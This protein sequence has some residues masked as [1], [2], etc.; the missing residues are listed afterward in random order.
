MGRRKYEKMKRTIINFEERIYLFLK[1]LAFERNKS[2]SDLVNEAIYNYFILQELAKQQLQR[3][4]KQQVQVQPNFPMGRGFS[5]GNITHVNQQFQQ[6]PEPETDEKKIIWDNISIKTSLS[7]ALW[8]I[9]EMKKH[10]SDFV[11]QYSTG[12]INWVAIN[13]FDKKLNGLRTVIG[14]CP[15]LV[16]M[17][18]MELHKLVERMVDIINQAKLG[19]KYDEVYCRIIDVDRYWKKYVNSTEKQNL[20]T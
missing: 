9:H 15:Q 14:R 2:V 4:V 7:T 6:P 5:A 3:E 16:Q 12:F 1:R 13:N 19:K 10:F 18:P 8:L 20:K 17:I 11:N